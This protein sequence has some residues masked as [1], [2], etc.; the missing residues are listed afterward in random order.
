MTYISPDDPPFLIVH[1]TKDDLV[2][3][4]QSELLEVALRKAGVDVTLVKIEGGG[5]VFAGPEV[6]MRVGAFFAK[7]LRGQNV[8]ISSTPIR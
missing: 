5:H 7:H 4:E 8:E 2:P 6:G 1:G 3:L